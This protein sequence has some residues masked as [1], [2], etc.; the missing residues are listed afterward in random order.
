MLA[1]RFDERLVRAL[2]DALAADVDPRAGSHL[3]EHH[4]PLAVELVE[5]FQRRPV[6]HEVRVGDEHARRIGMRAEH[7]DRLARLDQQRLVFAEPAQRGDDRVE[8]FPVAR[9]APD[10][11]VD[12]ELGRIFRDLGIEV[13]HQH[14]QRRFGQPRLRR[15]RGAPR[16]PDGAFAPARPR[17]YCAL[18]HRRSSNGLLA[19][20]GAAFPAAAQPATRGAIALLSSHNLPER[21]T[22]VQW[23]HRPHR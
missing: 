11:A 5:R 14:S 10:A 3:A 18:Q 22:T 23:Q 15:E 17:W 21:K 2:H 1:P 8:A 20:T 13:V 12:D 4:Q 16:C 6:R 7:A 9:G 19:G